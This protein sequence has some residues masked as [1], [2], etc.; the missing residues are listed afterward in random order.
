LNDDFKILNIDTA[1]LNV[2][3]RDISNMDIFMKD[4]DSDD[5]FL[6]SKNSSG[7]SKSS[8]GKMFGGMKKRKLKDLAEQ[9]LNAK[10]QEGHHSSV[11]DARTALALYRM[12]YESIETELRCRQAL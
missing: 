6:T 12:N 2:S 7:S 3:V 8:A 10:I 11:I 9:F 1:F 4:L 5:L